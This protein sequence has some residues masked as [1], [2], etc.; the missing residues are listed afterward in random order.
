MGQLWRNQFK[1]KQQKEEKEQQV[2][3]PSLFLSLFFSLSPQT[4]HHDN[5]DCTKRLNAQMKIKRFL[6]ASPAALLPPALLLFTP[7]PLPLFLLQLDLDLSWAD[8]HCDC[9]A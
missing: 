6:P 1:C 8:L 7:S 5:D 4:G 9:I 3:K 2:A